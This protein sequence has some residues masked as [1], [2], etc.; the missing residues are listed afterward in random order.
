MGKK[1]IFLSSDAKQNRQLSVILEEGGYHLT[2]FQELSELQCYIKGRDSLAVILDL[3]TVPL[4]NR[5][6][7][8]LALKNP[9]IFLLGLS[10][11]RFHPEL[12]DAICYHLFACINRPPDQNEL[13]D[14]LFYWLKTIYENEI[15]SNYQ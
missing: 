3:D 14:E 7:R 8:H 11:E 9:G 10:K 5:T 2:V 6:I 12:K 13:L 4:D 1:V 15:S